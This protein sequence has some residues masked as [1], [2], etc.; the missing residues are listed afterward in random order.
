MLQAINALLRE[1]VE[2]G[3]IC[4]ITGQNGDTFDDMIVEM[5]ER[6]SLEYVFIDQAPSLCH[7]LDSG[8]YLYNILIR[9]RNI[10]VVIT[11]DNMLALYLAERQ[12]LAS[13]CLHIRMPYLSYSEHCT[14]VLNHATPDSENLRHYLQHGGLFRMPDNVREFIKSSISSCV[15]AL[16]DTQPERQIFIWL[17]PAEEST[18][19]DQYVDTIL[20]LAGSDNPLR[21]SQASKQLQDFDVGKDEDIYEKVR[22]DFRQFFAMHGEDRR[23]F[24]R[25]TETVALLEFLIYSG[26]IK[27]SSNPI[28]EGQALYRCNIQIPFMRYHYADR[29][30]RL[31]FG[32]LNDQSNEFYGEQAEEMIFCEYEPDMYDF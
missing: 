8:D 31:F 17:R 23:Y 26:I 24:M 30:R 16:F 19:W 12:I 25:R 11:G 22:K 10:R 18:D 20:C 4:F 29:M 32:E 13:R 3:S 14:F 9:T 6:K 27:V 5:N 28:G 15:P 2:P 1:G 7:F 21:R